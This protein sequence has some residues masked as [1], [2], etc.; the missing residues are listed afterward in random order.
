MTEIAPRGTRPQRL[1]Q[2]LAITGIA[3]GISVIVAGLYLLVARPSCC[4]YMNMG[5]N[6]M[7]E[8][9]M[10]APSMSPMP[11]MPTASAPAPT[12]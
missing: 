2:A 4:D 5:R 3:V 11:G 10:N 1:Y 6:T 12:P 9:T 7:M 8:Q